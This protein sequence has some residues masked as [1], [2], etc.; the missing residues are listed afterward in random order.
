MTLTNKQP[1]TLNIASIQAPSPFSQ[2]N[3][4]GSALASGASCTVTV[5]FAPTAS[6]HYSSNLTI[7]DDAATSPQLVPLFGTGYSLASFTPM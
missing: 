7:T 6:Q 2:T 1:V 5:S 4:C 3:N